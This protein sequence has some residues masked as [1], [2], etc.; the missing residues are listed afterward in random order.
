MNI[1]LLNNGNLSWPQN[2]ILNIYSNY[3]FFEKNEPI[4][5]DYEIQSNKNINYN[6]KISMNIIKN[7]NY[8]IKT[9][10]NLEFVDKSKYIHQ[11]D[12]NLKFIIKHSKKEINNS[13]SN[14][15]LFKSSIPSNISN[16]NL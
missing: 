11:N 9:N 6:L 15:N 7:E 12:F 10:M 8:E 16:N 1:K 14:Q 5:N 3:G 2:S 13:N 4:N